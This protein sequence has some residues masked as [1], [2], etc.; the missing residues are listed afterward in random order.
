MARQL[1]LLG[2]KEWFLDE[3]SCA[4]LLLER[5]WPSDFVRPRC[6][7]GNAVLL[8]SRAY[9]DACRV[10]DEQTSVTTGTMMHRTK[11]PLRVW[12]WVAHLMATYSNGMLACQLPQ[13]L[14]LGSYN[15]AWLLAQELRAHGR[16]Y[17]DTLS[18]RVRL[19]VIPS[20]EAVHIPFRWI[21]MI[22][23]QLKRWGRHEHTA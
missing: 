13:Q 9:T 22:F 1:S 15:S 17:L 21:H 16:K 8:T 10:C 11:L 4:R 14:G 2:F 6:G 19:A 20:N 7:G 18:G 5:R 12:F 23:T 3:E